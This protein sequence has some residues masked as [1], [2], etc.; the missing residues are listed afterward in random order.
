MLRQT[1]PNSERLDEAAPQPNRPD[2]SFPSSGLG[3]HARTPRWRWGEGSRGKPPSPDAGPADTHRVEPLKWS[4]A[5]D[6]DCEVCDQPRF[7]V[8][9]SRVPPS[10]LTRP[11]RSPAT[12]PYR[13]LSLRPLC[14][15]T[16]GGSGVQ[17]GRRDG[18]YPICCSELMLPLLQIPP[19]QVPDAM[20]PRDT[21]QDPDRAG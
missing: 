19:V 2:A 13:R 17:V 1:A 16:A 12:P 7:C 11:R 3:V 6:R 21:R 20:A 4:S 10:N 9:D 15:P 8:S 18:C 5:Q 14:L